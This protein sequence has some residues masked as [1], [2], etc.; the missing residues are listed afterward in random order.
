[1]AP[2]S[3]KLSPVLTDYCFL[4]KAEALIDEYSQELREFLGFAEGKLSVLTYGA[5]ASDTDRLLY[6]FGPPAFR[7]KM[8]DYF[9]GRETRTLSD[10]YPDEKIEKIDR[11]L[12]Q[13]IRKGLSRKAKSRGH[14]TS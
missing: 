11:A 13:A 5:Q 2:L 14:T 3:V 4:P 1:M 9:A 10:L 12:V 7:R 6:L 8:L